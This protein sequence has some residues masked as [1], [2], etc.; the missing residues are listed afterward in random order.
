MGS[1]DMKLTETKVRE[2]VCPVG[3]KDALFFDDMLAGFGIRVGANGT[4]TF[5]AQYTLGGVKRRMPFGQFGDAKEGKLTVAKA[6]SRAM[7]IL[8][9]VQ[10]KRDPFAE[11][12]AKIAQVK[13][14]AAVNKQAITLDQLID[15]WEQDRTKAG[16]RDSYLRIATA[17]LRRAFKDDLGRA[18]ADL[19]EEDAERQIGQIEE[20]AGPIAANRLLAYGRACYGRGVRKRLVDFN[21][22]VRIDPPAAE[23]SRERVLTDAE[24]LT[25]WKAA[26]ALPAPYGSWVHM[27]ILTGQRRSEVAG[28]QW[29]ELSDGMWHMPSQRTKTNQPHVVHVTEQMQDVL[30]ERSKKSEFVFAGERGRP[31]CAYSYAKRQID[32]MITKERKKAKIEAWVWHDFR[33]TQ[34]TWMVRN[35][36]NETVADR[37]ANHREGRATG[38]KGVYQRHEF[39]PERKAALEAW[40]KHVMALAEGGEPAS[41]VVKLK[42]G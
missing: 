15:A 9:A 22:F 36:I 10:E 32:Q 17:A 35:G 27:L 29:S 30:E 38:I 16:K 2:L 18:A 20:D 5:I 4:R 21:P 37:I 34:Q 31:I 14:E 11:E 40:C 3:K 13:T 8:G 23:Q 42:V 12:K 33:R 19:S 7:A 39:L 24:L 1:A 6:R 41:N 28:M 26:D 25:I